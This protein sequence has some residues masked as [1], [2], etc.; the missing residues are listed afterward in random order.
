VE[1]ILLAGGMA[2]RLGDA[3][4]GRPKALVEIAGK[5]LAVHQ[6]LRL[7]DA[8]VDRVIVSCRAG[9]EDAFAQA[10]EE[11]AVELAFAA[12]EQPLGRGG[13]LKFAARERRESGPCFALN[14]DEL[15][16]L[17]LEALLTVHRQRSPAATIAVAPLPS[18]FGVVEIAEDGTVEGFRESPKLPHW[19]NMGLYVLDTEAIERLPDQGDHETSTFPELAEERKLLAFRHQG[20]WLTVNTPKDLRRAEEHFA[21]SRPA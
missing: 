10:L 2:E 7:S 13:G 4:Q 14:G 8:G 11:V 3:A 5:P 6:I 20:L 12:E 9:Q 1:A 16:D 21:A 17:D 19:V 18:P 15:F